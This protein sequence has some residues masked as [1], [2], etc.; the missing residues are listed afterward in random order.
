MIP[1]KR[2]VRRFTAFTTKSEPDY[3]YQIRR[4]KNDELLESSLKATRLKT[5]DLNNISL[6]QCSILI[7]KTGKFSQIRIPVKYSWR[8]LSSVSEGS[9]QAKQFLLL[10][11]TALIYRTK[12]I[13]FS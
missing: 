3:I 8:P 11:F 1:F 13:I 12:F 7:F 10:T 5:P 2:R 9:V 6:L 4:K